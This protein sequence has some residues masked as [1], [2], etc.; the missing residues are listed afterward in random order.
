M[1]AINYYD[2]YGVPSYEDWANDNATT[3]QV[4]VGT[5]HRNNYDYPIYEEQKVL[6][7]RSQYEQE[8]AYINEK[9][10]DNLLADLKTLSARQY[11][12][13]YDRERY[14]RLREGLEL[15]GINP[16]YAVNG[17]TAGTGTGVATSQTNMASTST[18]RDEMRVRN[19]ISDSQIELN[20]M[21]GIA[22]LVGALGTFVGALGGASHNFGFT[23]TKSASNVVGNYKSNT[24]TLFKDV[25][26]Y[27]SEVLYADGEVYKTSYK[28]TSAMNEYWSKK[29]KR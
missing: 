6:P 21:Q 17:A 18:A 23:T 2:L 9:I 20:K 13:Q 5:E 11:E 3:K 10:A 25:S 19:A 16:Y 24:S 7:T 4:Q 1:S 26:E 29:G 28:G 12:Q 27:L 14:L 15:A 8:F 22:S